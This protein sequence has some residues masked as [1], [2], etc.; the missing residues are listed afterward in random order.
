MPFVQ[1]YG[2]RAT[3]PGGASLA[4]SEQ[5]RQKLGICFLQIVA[6]LGSRQEKSRSVLPLF[7][8]FLY[9]MTINPMFS[10][11]VA[12]EESARRIF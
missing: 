3:Q 11:A 2:Q 5:R 4:G 10:P 1:L 12:G 6:Q 8:G 9:A 7:T